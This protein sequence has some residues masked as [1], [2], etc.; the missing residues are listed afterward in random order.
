LVDALCAR[1]QLGFLEA[2]Y[3][4]PDEPAP[5]L[6]ALAGE[7]AQAATLAGRVRVLRPA[8][9]LRAFEEIL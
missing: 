5:G 1:S 8:Y 2:H 7:F 3:A 9:L 6:Q 4:M